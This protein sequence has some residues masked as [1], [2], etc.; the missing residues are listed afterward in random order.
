M[1]KLIAFVMILSML[2][3]LAFAEDARVANWAEVE[4]MLSEMGLTGDFTV[5]EQLGLKIR[6]PVLPLI[7]RKRKG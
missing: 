4:P 2:C 6:P 1:K 7:W 3:S 5:F